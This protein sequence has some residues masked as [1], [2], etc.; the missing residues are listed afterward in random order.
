MT[1]HL[2]AL[3]AGA[4]STGTMGGT[5]RCG[6]VVGARRPGS[7]RCS[8]SL[9]TQ[10]TPSKHLLVSGPQFLPGTSGC[11]NHERPRAFHVNR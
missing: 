3:P 8:P 5:S 7:P 10:A 9:S 1:P 4:E 11:S 2:T 6:P